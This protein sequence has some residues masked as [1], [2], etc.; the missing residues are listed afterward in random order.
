LHFKNSAEFKI[1][2]PSQITIAMNEE[3]LATK[4]ISEIQLKYFTIIIKHTQ[5]QKG[6]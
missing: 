1:P 3:V 2:L 6:K 5:V 4:E